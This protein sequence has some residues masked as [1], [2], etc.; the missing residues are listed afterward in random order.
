MVM[1]GIAHVESGGSK[2]PYSLMSKQS[3]NGDRAYGKYQIM[4]N[5]I[6]SWTKTATGQS[7]TPEQ[8]MANPAIQEKTAAFMMNQSLKKGYSPEDTASIWFSGRPQKKAGNSKD[9]YGTTVP[10]YVKKFQSGVNSYVAQLRQGTGQGPKN[11]SPIQMQQLPQ[12]ALQAQPI[13]KLALPP[14]QPTDRQHSNY[15]DLVRALDQGRDSY[16][17]NQGKGASFGILQNPLRN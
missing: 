8:F 9:V 4:G 3:K 1:A 16:S 7:Y 17:Q 15:E 5:N 2:D 11:Q 6:P 10:A 12:T 14:Q 13:Q